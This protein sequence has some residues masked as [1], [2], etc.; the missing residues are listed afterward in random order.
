MEVRKPE[1]AYWLCQAGGWGLYTLYVLSL[2]AQ[3]ERGWHAKS[4]VSIVG[5]LLIVSP[6]ATHGLRAWI[7][8]HG[9]LEM[10]EAR[11]LPRAALAVV[12]MAAGL[13]LLTA[14][15]NVFVLRNGDWRIWFPRVTFGIATGFAMALSI[16]LWIYVRVQDRRRRRALELKALRLEVVAHDARLRAL[17]SQLNPHFLFNSL[18]SVRALVVEDPQRAQTM[19]TRLAELLRYTLRSGEGDVVMLDAEVRAV[20]DYLAIERVRF[21]ERL[22]VEVDVDSAA[23]QQR[24]P[25]MLVLTLVENAVK[26][27][28][29]RLQGGGTVRIGAEIAGDRLRVRVTNS[30]S[31]RPGA[32]G[33]G[34]GLR[35]ARERLQLIYGD[36]ASL[37]LEPDGAFV[38]ARVSMP[39]GT[40]A[41]G[42]M[43][44]TA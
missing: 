28:I 12:S 44:A 26:H 10:T 17:E 2:S 15:V 22:T 39:L 33:A 9:W 31:L 18:N 40:A 13:A 32:T 5:F 23:R 4:I 8:R 14:L 42:A 30:G 11:M 29:G 3:Y 36:T 6:L 37:T 21:E 38:V 20:E 7:I 27:G 35:N 24:V 43:E 25:R 41:A 34:L 1:R 19:I 16:W